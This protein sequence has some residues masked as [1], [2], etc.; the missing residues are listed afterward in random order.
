MAD[1]KRPNGVKDET[2][3][4]LVLPD[5]VLGE[6]YVV[7]RNGHRGKVLLVELDGKELE[8]PDEPTLDGIYEVKSPVVNKP[9][10]KAPAVEKPSPVV[11]TAPTLEPVVEE[12]PVE[13]KVEE[14]PVEEPLKEELP[15]PVEEL[16]E[17]T[18]PL[19]ENE[20]VE[21][22]PTPVEELNDEEDSEGEE[23]ESEEG[24]EEVEKISLKE[25]YPGKTFEQR[26]Y[27][28]GEVLREQYSEIKNE[29]LSF[30]KVKARRTKSCETFRHGYDII[31]KVVVAG[32]GL[33]VYLALDPLS[34]DSA[35][36]HQRDASSKK[37]FA[38]VPLVVKVRTPLA[39]RK[40]KTLIDMACEGKDTQKKARYTVVDYS[41]PEQKDIE[42]ED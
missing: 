36:Y 15:E 42:D 24:S 14:A 25:K 29:F 34:V 32:K 12:T 17:E 2:P 20:D 26:L 19:E 9:V 3:L 18:A 7:E 1:E 31:G 23:E 16:D 37:R 5:L 39:V 27:D 40:A 35:I 30:R 22:I 6:L 4:E 11:E 28:A 38:M 21:I 13:A 8:V 33:K 10:R 41:N